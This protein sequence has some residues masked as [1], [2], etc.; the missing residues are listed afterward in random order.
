MP[1]AP[2]SGRT[3]ADLLRVEPEPAV[4]AGDVVRLLRAIPVDHPGSDAPAGTLVNGV[5]T[6]SAPQGY[7]A[8]FIGRT[9]RERSRLARVRDLEGELA[10]VNQL[11]NATRAVL[12]D[13]EADIRAARAE[14]DTFPSADKI[15][16]SRREIDRLRR[17][18]ATTETRVS[19]RI[20]EAELALQRI[21][22]ELEQA[23]TTRAAALSAA[24]TAMNHAL[25]AATE[26]GVKAEA[27]A[28][29]AAEQA[30][31]AEAS[32]RARVHAETAQRQADGERASFPEQQL[33]QVQ[34]VHQA[35]DEA[36]SALNHARAALIKATDQHRLAGGEVRNALR[37]LN[38]A[39][40]LP[41]GSLLPTTETGLAD[42]NDQTQS[43]GHLVLR[44]VSA[45][46][47]TTDLLKAAG[48][49]A[50]TSTYRATAAEKAEEEAENRRLESKRQAA[51]VAEA[52][53]LHGT[54][55]ETQRGNRQR[56]V[57][58]LEDANTV[59]GELLKDQIEAAGKAAAA[60]TTLTNVAPQRERA[61]QRRDECLRNLSRLVEEG[62]AR[63]PEDVPADVS[64][65]PA[66]LTAGLT[67]ARRMLADRP[68]GT[69]RM[70]ALTQARGKLL[71]QLETSVRTASAALARFGRQ[72]TL[73]TIDGTDWRRA[74]VADPEAT[75]GEDLHR[76]IEG[77]RKAA[78]Q[79]EGD[80]R[81]DVKRAMKTG[82]FTQ[83]QQ[84]VQLRREAAQEL[85]R[86]IRETLAGV[87]TGVANVGVEVDWQVRKD[88]DAQR[89]VELI[90][91][92]P[93][94]EVYEQMYTVL[95][96]RMDETAGE[97]WKDRI[98]HAFDYR[99]WH[100]WEIKVTHSS[101]AHDGQEK[102][103]DVTT[104]SNPLDSLSTGER[105]LATMLPL[106]AA[107]WS[108]YSGEYTGPRLLSI[109]EI[110]AAFDEPNLRQV[111]ALLRTWQFDVLATA[112]S[113][114]P[115]FKQ[116]TG[117]AI[118][119][120]VIAAG[121]HRVTIPWIWE[122]HGEPQPLTLDFTPG[123]PSE[124]L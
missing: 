45:A 13:R 108:M 81:E 113:M 62:L 8:A 90:S 86:K 85:V 107:A 3:L 19:E 21:L 102:F 80:L 32:E 100:D 17:N 36:T 116:E 71:G 4:E 74:V 96:Q 77:L 27:A 78:E 120:Q 61:E 1:A 119:H 123:D 121:K 42:H 55:Y 79:L 56:L 30:E 118:I 11:L 101:F 104:R 22:A 65:R 122:G 75:R 97:E 110:D 73:V 54:E 63:M 26:A 60:R 24:E 18:L 59:A 111:L 40:A 25:R 69:D 7:C 103:R 49:A 66:N 94:D 39:A 29:K 88:E 23:A 46:H 38:K 37:A 31:K 115:M 33:R 93:S 105:R 99:S 12:R 91:Q 52:R 58:E 114:T 89:M 72:V 41:D 34:A 57:D 35:E 50:D 47:R 44:W 43:L 92:P 48:R 84:D 51:A 5:L 14:L 6:A 70:T 76:T 53:R 15:T 117:R 67:W 87:R 83:L 68:A 106:L 109:D 124:G 64:G 112:P 98:E 28:A 10:N 9:T 95:R 20:G 82:L 16:E 2:A